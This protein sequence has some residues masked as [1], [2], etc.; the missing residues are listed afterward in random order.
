MQIL[1]AFVSESTAV[2]QQGSGHDGTGFSRLFSHYMEG[3]PAEVTPTMNDSYAG[4][5]MLADSNPHANVGNDSDMFT[6][7]TPYISTASGVDRSEIRFTE[8]EVRK[9]AKGLQKEGMDPA[10]VNAVL[11]LAGNPM[12]VTTP[13]IMQAIVGAIRK[14]AQVTDEDMERIGG[15]LSQLD[16]EGGLSAN[17]TD[18]LLAGRTH[19]AWGR[20]SAALSAMDLES[21]L[22]VNSEDITALGKALALSDTVL[23]ALRKQ[24]G[25]TESVTTSPQGMLRMMASAQQ[26]LGDKQ[27]ELE[28]LAACFEKVLSPVAQEARMRLATEDAANGRAQ[29]SVEQSAVLIRDTVTQKALERQLGLVDENGEPV[30]Q[31]ADTSKKSQ[32]ETTKKSQANALAKNKAETPSPDKAE[33]PSPDKVETPSSDKAETQL[34]DRTESRAKTMA[35]TQADATTAN[36]KTAQDSKADEDAQSSANRDQGNRGGADTSD[37][38]HKPEKTGT[39]KTATAWDSLADRIVYHEQ[40]AVPTMT[41]SQNAQ[42]QPQTQAT[43]PHT[44]AQVLNQ[45]EQGMLTAMRDGSQKLELQLT[46]EHLGAVTVVLTTTKNGEISALLKAEKPETAAALT[47]Q[48]EHLRS[49]LEQQGLKVDKVEVQTQLQDH[50]GNM[51]WQGMDQHNASQEQQAQAHAQE[52]QRI[53]RLGRLHR[54]GS[55]AHLERNMHSGSQQA[56]NAENTAER[57][58]YIVA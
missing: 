18:D 23:E 37:A 36:R 52:Q 44:S 30:A 41:A 40:A 49:I 8:K 29:R 33:T 20:I 50:R 27:T 42:M 24:F 48:S 15:L 16:P 51:Q 5:Q 2:P 3:A 39:A 34:A 43:L 32:A 26:E 38:Q 19:Q 10:V 28:K 13:D 54:G 1:P 14:A 11:E 25:G 56:H 58:L 22:Q 17:V 55:D 47:Q 46:P 12:G 7:K 6:A 4:K 31:A 45:V 21:S 57:G 35:E 9:I 53:M